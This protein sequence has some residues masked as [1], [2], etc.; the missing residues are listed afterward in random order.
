M[1]EQIYDIG[2]IL[3]ISVTVIYI[4]T[5]L[6][7]C[8]IHYLKGYSIM[9]DRPVT[10]G[11]LYKHK[12]NLPDL[13]LIGL[14]TFMVGVGVGYAWPVAVLFLIAYLI[15]KRNK[16]VVDAVQILKGEV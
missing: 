2:R 10:T 11:N 3:I 8:L 5:A 13:I 14:A 9:T 12:E 16:R 1:I 7:N 4:A 15:H 6:L